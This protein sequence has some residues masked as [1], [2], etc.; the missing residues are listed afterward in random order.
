[1]R[2]DDGKEDPYQR[3]PALVVGANTLQSA[4]GLLWAVMITSAEN[5]GWVGDVMVSDLTQAGLP[6]DSLVRTA[7][8]ATI[9]A[10]DA[11]RIG[12]LPLT[13]RKAVEDYIRGSLARAPR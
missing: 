9:E 3:R 10:D 8:M 13:D 2:L 6:A 11:L 7:K 12:T 4:H 5:R 1:V